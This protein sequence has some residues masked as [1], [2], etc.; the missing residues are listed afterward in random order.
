[1]P[2]LPF[3]ITTLLFIRNHEGRFLLL[4]RTNPPNFGCWSPPGG[5]LEMASGESPT[6]CAIREAS[7]EAGMDLVPDDLHLWGMVS[8]KNYEGSGH[9]LMFM[10]DV[11]ARIDARPPRISEGHFR[12]FTRAEI[13]SLKV[14]ETDRVLLWPYYDRYRGKFIAYRVDCRPGGELNVIVEQVTG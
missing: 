7:E 9:W 10:F 1:M 14:P 13:D 11:L 5:K 8:E 4:E 3:R 2:D 12:F 6:E